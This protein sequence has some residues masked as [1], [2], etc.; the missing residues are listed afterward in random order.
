[1]SRTATEEATP[2]EGARSLALVMSRLGG[3]QPGCPMLVTLAEAAART[4]LADSSV[5]LAVKLASSPAIS[6]R[7]QGIVVDLAE[8]AGEV[9]EFTAPRLSFVES[10]FLS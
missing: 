10:G 3:T 1:M 4:G 6:S 2:L 9:C 8:L 7:A 5:E